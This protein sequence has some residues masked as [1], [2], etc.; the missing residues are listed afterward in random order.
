M[1]VN[2]AT[3]FWNLGMAKINGKMLAK[4]VPESLTDKLERFKIDLHQHIVGIV[5]NGAPVMVKW[6]N[7]VVYT[8][9][10]ACL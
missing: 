2:S 10:L 3:K 8:N 9:K 6:G 7:L 4:K 5:R 1:N